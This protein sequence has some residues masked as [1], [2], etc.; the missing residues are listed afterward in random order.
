MSLLVRGFQTVKFSDLTDKEHRRGRNAGTFTYERRWD[1]DSITMTVMPTDS[2]E[3]TEIIVSADFLFSDEQSIAHA[4]ACHLM[5]RFPSVQ[6]SLWTGKT[7]PLPD[8]TSEWDPDDLSA[9]V[10]LTIENQ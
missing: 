6:C 8:K 4:F 10:K 1:Q 2:S 3:E 5:S 7:F 9:H